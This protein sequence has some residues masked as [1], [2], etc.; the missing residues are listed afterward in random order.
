MIVPAGAIILSIS[1][2]DKTTTTTTPTT[3]TPTNTTPTSPTPVT[4]SVGNFYGVMAAV[5][6]DFS[7]EV[8]V[9]GQTKISSQI[10]VATFYDNNNGSGNIV[11]AGTVSVNSNTFDKQSN[12]SYTSDATKTDLGF[13]NGVNWK[14]TGGN[15]IPSIN[16]THSG[17]FPGYSGT[18]PTEIDKSKDLEID[19]GSKVTGADSV[20]LVLITGSTTIIK[21]YDGNPAPS[22]GVIPASELSGLT[23][24]TDNSAYLEVVPFTY[25]T[26]TV[27]GKQFVAIKETAAVAGVNIK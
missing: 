1:S 21:H 2:C 3:N 5:K 9:I 7:Y 10:G 4:P 13:S 14:V 17:S 15:G 11:D 22:K 6:M 25:K 26:P 24:V 23:N 20:Y 19:L 16:Y 18:L 12:N 27:S 8:P